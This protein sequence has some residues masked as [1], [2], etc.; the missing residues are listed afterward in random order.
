MGYVR[1]EQNDGTVTYTGAW[2]NNLADPR[3]SGGSFSFTASNGA[4]IDIAIAAGKSAILPVIVQSISTGLVSVALDGVTQYTYNTNSGGPAG[5]GAGYI[6]FDTFLPPVYLNPATTHTLTITNLSTFQFIFDGFLLFDTS[7]ALIPGTLLGYGHSQFYGLTENNPVIATQ[8]VPTI[9]QQVG[10][11]LTA[12]TAWTVYN[13]SI[14]GED[15][16][17]GAV[18]HRLI[19]SANLTGGNYTITHTLTNTGATST[20]ASLGV[21]ANAATINGALAAVGIQWQVNGAAGV[22]FLSTGQ[23]VNIVAMSG[24][25]PGTLTI[26]P[27]AITG[28]T[29][30]METQNNQP[31]YSNGYSPESGHRRALRGADTGST[32]TYYWANSAFGRVFGPGQANGALWHAAK[33]EIALLFHIYNDRG[34][35]TLYE[36][37]GV[38]ST[39]NGASGLQQVQTLTPSGTVSG[40]T[41]TVSQGGNTSPAISVLSNVSVITTQLAAATPSPIPFT[42]TGAAGSPLASGSAVTLTGNTARTEPAN[43]TVNP[44]GVTGGGTLTMGAAN[45]VGRPTLATA[46]GW[47]SARQRK[48]TQDLLW[49]MNCASPNTIIIVIST[50]MTPADLTDTVMIPPLSAAMMSLCE[51]RDSTVKNTYWCDVS[52]IPNENGGASGYSIWQQQAFNP[53]FQSAHMTGAGCAAVGNAIY[54]RIMQIKRGNA[55]RFH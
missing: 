11:M 22:S 19:P 45:P 4:K 38:G 52:N 42:A 27:T 33:P 47:V 10:G 28:G 50:A 44:A 41:F 21:F 46:A 9:P 34:Y 20:T 7:N 43:L 6:W 15:L 30:T 25:P 24:A 39:S 16:C 53:G 37:P 49:A 35:V 36:T 54:N 40:G 8:V 26:T 32:V 14:P 31:Y 1:A 48:Y 3:A 2:T 29:L 51:G 23:I 18:S 13:Q 12:G 17:N 5:S 55:L